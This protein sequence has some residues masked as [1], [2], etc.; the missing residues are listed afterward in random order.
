[1]QRMERISARMSSM[2]ANLVRRYSFCLWT[3]R[4]YEVRMRPMK[5]TNIRPCLAAS[6]QVCRRSCPRGPFSAKFKNYTVTQ[7]GVSLEDI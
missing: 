5:Q 4:T 3:E 6:D 2:D 1:M 7:K